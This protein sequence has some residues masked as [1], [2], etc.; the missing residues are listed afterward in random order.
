MATLTKHSFFLIRKPLFHFSPPRVFGGKPSPRPSEMVVSKANSGRSE[1]D[2]GLEIFY[3]DEE[4]IVNKTA[5][6]TPASRIKRKRKR[7]III[8]SSNSSDDDAPLVNLSMMRKSSNAPQK[9][10]KCQHKMEI[11]SSEY[12]TSITL[13]DDATKIQMQPHGDISIRRRRKKM[14]LS[15]EDSDDDD[16]DDDDDEKKKGDEHNG[17]SSD[18][19]L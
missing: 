14:R 4:E 11:S 12:A 1:D 16:D 8:D 2:D 5:I 13:A 17:T 6:T 15:I 10:D 18:D 9:L 7:R 19:C 3:D